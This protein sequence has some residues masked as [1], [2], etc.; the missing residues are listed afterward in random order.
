MM[1][2]NRNLLFQRSIFRFH[3]CFGGCTSLKVLYDHVSCT[4][5]Y[6]YIYPSSKRG[7]NISHRFVKPK[8]HECTM[9]L[10]DIYPPSTKMFI[11]KGIHIIIISS[12]YIYYMYLY[13]YIIYI[14][15]FIFKNSPANNK[16]KK[17]Q[18]NL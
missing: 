8:I 13:T 15:I 16:Y 14:Y 3:V 5:S 2:P 11:D 6:L 1:V 4:T 12:I 17:I 10:V 18:V 9:S 7:K